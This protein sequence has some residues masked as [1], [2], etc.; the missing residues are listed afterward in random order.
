MVSV[1]SVESSGARRRQLLHCPRPCPFSN[2]YVDNYWMG[3]T[4]TAYRPV[5]VFGR[6]HECRSGGNRGMVWRQDNG[7]IRGLLLEGQQW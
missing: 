6:L 1:A 5:D 3:I 2:G 7:A 4:D